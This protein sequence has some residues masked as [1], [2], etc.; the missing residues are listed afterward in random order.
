MVR[1]LLTPRWLL[2]HAVAVL[3]MLVCFR[4]GW[5]QWD[6][7]Q[8]AGGTFQNLGYALQWPLFGLFVPFMYWRMYKL[9]QERAAAEDAQQAEA[10]VPAVP[11]QP[12]S[13][14]PPRRSPTEWRRAAA[15]EQ[16]EDKAL[17]EYNSYLAQL[18]AKD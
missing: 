10:A 8:E 17:A 16:P 13:Q 2:L 14:D 18:N 7:S 9:D 6:R 11:E 5:W 12:V 1:R 4:L 15:V 3:A